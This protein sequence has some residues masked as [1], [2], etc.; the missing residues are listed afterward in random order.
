[1]SECK[2]VHAL[3]LKALNQTEKINTYNFCFDD[4]I[5]GLI[6]FSIAQ[7]KQFNS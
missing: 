4:G 2:C 5:C 3:N 1:M 7:V 6:V